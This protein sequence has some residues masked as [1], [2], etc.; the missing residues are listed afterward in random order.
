MFR[1]TRRVSIP[2]LERI[3]KIVGQLGTT[4]SG[5]WRAENTKSMRELTESLN[6][7]CQRHGKRFQAPG[8]LELLGQVVS[9][10]EQIAGEPLLLTSGS[11]FSHEIFRTPSSPFD[12][13][14][15]LLVPAGGMR[16]IFRHVGWRAL[17]PGTELEG[18]FRR[19]MGC[20]R[21]SKTCLDLRV[22]ALAGATTQTPAK[23]VM[24]AD[25]AWGF[26]KVYFF[27]LCDPN[28]SIPAGGSALFDLAHDAGTGGLVNGP[29][30]SE[31][32]ACDKHRRL[33]TMPNARKDSGNR[34]K[35]KSWTAHILSAMLPAERASTTTRWG[36]LCLRVPQQ[37]SLL[38]AVEYSPWFRDRIFL[39]GHMDATTSHWVACEKNTPRFWRAATVAAAASTIDAC[40]SI[41]TDFGVG[42]FE[43][44]AC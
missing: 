42:N 31:G 22:F 34:G 39:C 38:T 10:T 16:R 4:D 28:S 43:G 26:I 27:P 21:N 11:M 17:Q 37:A 12:D 23:C 2:A 1:I 33:L 40:R 6:Q 15:D 24:F 44:A 25:M 14:V 8:R 5:R 29:C 41:C 9:F 35:H 19:W 13:D 7:S 20:G 32:K 36:D 3:A 30:L 18:V